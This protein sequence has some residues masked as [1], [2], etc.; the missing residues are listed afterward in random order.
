MQEPTHL[1]SLS[2]Y[3]LTSDDTA[4]MIYE[5]SYR[6]NTQNWNQTQQHSRQMKIKIIDV[7]ALQGFYNFLI[8]F[9]LT[10]KSTKL[11]NKAETLKG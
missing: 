1:F 7:R 8:P 3:S 6:E 4:V 9:S 2:N 11:F 5:K 10:R